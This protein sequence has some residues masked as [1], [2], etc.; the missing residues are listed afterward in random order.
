MTKTEFAQRLRERIDPLRAGI[1]VQSVRSQSLDASR[2]ATNFGEYFVYFSFF[3]VVSA[4]L[5]SALFFKLNVERRIREVGLLRALACR[6]L[7]FE[8]FI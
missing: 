2:G 5:L 6:L 3:L 7:R 4:L 8:R 1:A